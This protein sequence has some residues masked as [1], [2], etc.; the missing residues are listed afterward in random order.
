MKK[1]LEDLEIGEGKVKL[2][3]DEIKAILTEHGKS[4]NA[5]KEKVRTELD[6]EIETYKNQLKD[7]N[8]EI[9]S[10]KDMDIDSIKQSA[11]NW[12]TKYNELVKSQEEA[13]KE[14]IR[15]E[16]TNAFFNGVE[17]ASESA[18]TGVIAQFNEKDFKYDEKEQ[19]FQGA[20]EWLE[21]LKKNDSGA[22]KSDVANPRFTTDVTPPTN[23]STN[24]EIRKVMG[25][26]TNKK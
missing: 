1:Y 19:K 14:S 5:E 15:K 16:R 21:E 8:Q 23:S 20:S 7:A 11:T 26:E 4:V 6:T 25:L 2:S 12:E 10:Y 22:F 13:Q 24:D 3:E 17:F 18:K 9:Q